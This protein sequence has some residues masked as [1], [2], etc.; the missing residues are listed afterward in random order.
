VSQVYAPK[1]SKLKRSSNPL[2][3][4]KYFERNLK[5]M[6][7]VSV[8][9]GATFLAATGHWA[10]PPDSASL[11]NTELR[12]FFRTENIDYLDLDVLLNH[13]DFT[14]HVDAVHWTL[15]G[16]DQVAERW[17]EKIITVDSLKLNQLAR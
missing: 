17:K 10:Q 13:N 5:L 11:L 16:L 4:A 7:G 8:E 6:R 12:R 9:Y 2:Q 3:G 14:I 15:K 1:L